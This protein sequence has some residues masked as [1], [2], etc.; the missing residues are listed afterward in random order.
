MQDDFGALKE[1]LKA[2]ARLAPATF[3][4]RRKA[5]RNGGIG[6]MFAKPITCALAAIG[7]AA[8]LS[9]SLATLNARRGSSGVAD[10]SEALFCDGFG[11]FALSDNGGESI[12][13]LF[14]PR[15]IV[16]R[17]HATSMIRNLPSQESS[18]TRHLSAF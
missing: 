13:A 12:D 5:E 4:G 18:A 8:F 7:S 2:H 17:S 16:V 11:T 6:Q 10:F 3:T 14:N 15:R 9:R 1:L